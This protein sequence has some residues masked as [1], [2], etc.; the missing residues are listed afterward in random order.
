MV[1]C[2]S[3]VHFVVLVPRRTVYGMLVPKR[4]KYQRAKWQ[5][6][7]GNLLEYLNLY[8]DKTGCFYSIVRTV[9][10][11]DSIV[12]TVLSTESVLKRC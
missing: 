5:E 7:K 9:L 4:A 1:S 11:T 8:R 12:R 10:S 2:H 6:G 3:S